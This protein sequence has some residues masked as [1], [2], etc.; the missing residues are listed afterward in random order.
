MK[1]IGFYLALSLLINSV[2]PQEKSNTASGLSGFDGMKWG[3]DYKEAKDKFRT[4]ASSGETK[5]PVSII[6]DIPDTEFKVER[7]KLVYR[8]L[9][10]KKPEILLNQKNQNSPTE[11]NTSGDKPQQGNNSTT[12]DNDKAIPRLFLVE[13]TFPYV[14]AE[15]LY[16]KISAK[17]GARNGGNLDDKT[18]R[19]YY[20]WNLDGGYV[21]Q[22]IDPYMKK[23]FSRSIYY[24]SKEIVEEIKLDFPKFQYS[25]EL[26]ILKD[27]L[28]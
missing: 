15:E 17:Y 16:N 14:P 9:F 22:W 23:P 19:G 21:I 5:E 8:Y 18:N 20:L 11:N 3:T 4:L 28:Y 12:S 27:I 24:L 25:N 13:S 1:K 7:S 6:A 10:Y 26:K 2:Y